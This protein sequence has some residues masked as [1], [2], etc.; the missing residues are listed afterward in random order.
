[1]AQG[2]REDLIGP[3]RRVVALLA[4]DNI[5]QV[6]GGSYQKRSLKDWYARPASS[7]SRRAVGPSCSRDPAFQQP[8]GVI[9][10]RI[11]L[12]GLTAPRRDDPV[13]RPWRPSRSVDSPLAPVAAARP[14]DRPDAEVR[15]TR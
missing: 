2:D 9:P 8:Q 4:I 12:D 6:P 3:A 5:E 14:L 13:V 15:A 7:A 10:Q 1:M 11:D